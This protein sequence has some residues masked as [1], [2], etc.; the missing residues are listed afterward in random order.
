MNIESISTTLIQR[1]SQGD[2]AASNRLMELSAWLL[3]RMTNRIVYNKEDVEDVVQ[4][5]LAAVFK[6]ISNSEL[7]LKHGR[8]SY[9]K[10]LKTCLRNIAA[11]HIRK[12]QIHSPGGTDNLIHIHNLIDENIETVE[13]KRDIAEGVIEFAGLTDQEKQV[14]R[15]IFLS[16]KSTREISAELDKTAANIR[17]IQS[18]ALRKIRDLLGEDL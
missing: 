7:R 8:H 17:Q 5:A 15:L 3:H 9:I 14:L 10:L 11:N 1:A 18:R 13:E 4:E 6:I 2:R 12:K 16:G